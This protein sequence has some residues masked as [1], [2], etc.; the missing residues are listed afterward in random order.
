MP[1]NYLRSYLN[2]RPMHLAIL[3]AAECRLYEDLSLRRP[4]LDVGCGDGFFATVAFEEPL[5]VGI[6]VSSKSVK[7]AM[8][9]GGYRRLDISSSA[10]LAYPDRCFETVISNSVLEHIPNLDDTLSEIHRVLRREGIFVFTVPAGDYT[11]YLFGTHIFKSLRLRPLA[12]LYARYMTIISRHYHYLSAGIW[13]KKL[14]KAGFQILD[15]RSYFGRRAVWAFDLSH[16]LG[17]VAFIWK[18]I[19]NRWVLFPGRRAFVPLDRWLSPFAKPDA[20]KQGA[21]FFFLCQ[22]VSR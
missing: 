5:D 17:Y 15:H 10:A 8:R 9:S 16:Y 18:L 1:G 13:L 12:N 21:Y 2:Q 22:K 6:D 3:R 14:E 4:I 7:E 19:F 20:Q 11:D